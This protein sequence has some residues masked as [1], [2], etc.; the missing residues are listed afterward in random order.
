MGKRHKNE[1]NELPKK[2]FVAKK[3]QIENSFKKNLEPASTGFLAKYKL[4]LSI[5]ATLILTF[6]IYTSSLDNE[7]LN[8]DDDR[9]ITG[10]EIIKELNAESIMKFFSEPYFVMYM[11]FTLLSYS[12]DYAIGE[13]NPLVY[14]IHTLL[15]HLLNT[16]MLFIFV[17]RLMKLKKPEY[18]Y[19]YASI[20]AL[21]FGVHTI[22]VQSISWLAE[23][24][25]VLYSL[26]FLISLLM[27]TEYLRTEKIK[28]III[29]L[30]A[31]L[32]SVMSKGQAVALSL[33]VVAID[34]Y[35]GRKLLDKKLIIEKIPYFVIS[36][37]FG[38]V[39]LI[40]Q[41]GQEPFAKYA[42][43]AQVYELL[44]RS[45]F[46]NIIYAGYGY[47]LYLFKV[48]IPNNLSMVHFYPETEPGVIPGFVWLACIP[49]L[50]V[51]IVGI[52][53]LKKSGDI[54]FGILF[55]TANLVLMLQ[56]IADQPFL[57]A[58]H[59]GYIS[60][61]GIFFLFG[62]A[63]EKI[64]EKMPAL[65]K[66]ALVIFMGY[67]AFLSIFTYFRNDVF[68]NSET[69]WTN[70]LEQYPK[71]VVAYYNR[72]NYYQE[73]GDSGKPE[74]YEKAIKDYDKTIELSPKDVAA[75]SNRG[76]VRGKTGNAKG[77][78]EDFDKVV[79]ID[80]NFANVYSNRGNAKIMN[81][82]YKS[83]ID[84]Y[85]KAL[86]K[87]PNYLDALYNRG[88]AYTN[89]GDFKNAVTDLNQAIQM[90]PGNRNAILNRAISLYNLNEFE[91]CEKDCNTLLKM[92][93][94]EYN[95]MYFLAL[96]SEKNGKPQEA[97]SW[98]DKINTINPEFV[99][100]FIDEGSWYEARNQMKTALEK[101]NRALEINPEYS[102]GYINL[103][104]LFGRTGDLN[105][106]ISYFDKA[107]QY[108][109]K[110]A[111]AL[112]NR[113][114]AKQQIG[115]TEEALADYSASINIDLNFATSYT[116]RGILYNKIGKYKEALEDY[117][118][119]IKLE[120]KVAVV[121]IN[122]ALVYLQL[123]DLQNACNDFNTAKTL[124]EKNA[125]SYIDKY[126]K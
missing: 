9:Y 39:A 110:N 119:A 17:Y 44:N 33:T 46:E 122:R 19:A 118:N 37:I 90:N 111:K 75:F 38:A 84:D 113:A 89:V 23:R 15:L 109:P 12:I 102:D 1:G 26:F 85:S 96:M 54:A 79:E 50:L 66:P 101:Y 5:S 120:P 125:D 68:Q 78:L 8:W 60:S 67:I 45:L 40:A 47:T 70:V 62:F 55:F 21:L 29:S 16:L 13:L 98:F 7:F 123:K 30:I 83:A 114:F 35:L 53:A 2:Q 87:R 106:A 108:N 51:T 92:N 91:K 48:L 121:Y 11:P 104:V 107:I 73:I 99:K 105:K 4:L 64:K 59:Y 112:T 76:I 103:G 63:Y 10:N 126:C 116:N 41:K 34:Y 57:I 36:A 69:A 28:F 6:V 43:T 81:N 88:I 22:H 74:F 93:Q 25:D 31:F 58:E 80:P 42:S 32:I 56:V 3:I 77:A 27:Y 82:D 117:S 124:G 95:A 20:I 72:G 52:F 49:T 61:I 97:R 115:N 14:H 94:Q 65:M 71:T 100:T 18:A 24:K 86:E